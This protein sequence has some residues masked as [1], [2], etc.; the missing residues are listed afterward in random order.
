MLMGKVIGTVVASQKDYRLE[1][2]KLLL[3][4]QVTPEMK[5][6]GST[7]VAV[8]SVGAGID[9]IVLY[10]AG[11]SARLTNITENKPVDTVI[12]AIVDTVEMLG[13]VTYQK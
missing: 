11:S 9:E 12:V 10:S 1:G 6:T 3:I 8:D 13:T 7:V 4:E 5:E 2:L